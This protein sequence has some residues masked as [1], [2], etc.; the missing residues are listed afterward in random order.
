MPDQPSAGA[1]GSLKC[2]RCRERSLCALFYPSKVIYGYLALE[3]VSSYFC[4]QSQG[5]LLAS[6]FVTFVTVQGEE[7]RVQL[8]KPRIKILNSDVALPVPL[9]VDSFCDCVCIL[10][11]FLPLRQD[12]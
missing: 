7:L 4:F 3:I 1:W 2:R 11:I 10:S 5:R 6:A 8:F 9:G 12:K